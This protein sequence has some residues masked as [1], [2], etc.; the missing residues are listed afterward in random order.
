MP[1]TH[2]DFAQGLHTSVCV[3]SIISFDLLLF[4]E[5]QRPKQLPLTDTDKHTHTHAHS[6]TRTHK[7]DTL[8]A[9]THAWLSRRV[10]AVVCGRGSQTYALMKMYNEF[11]KCR[12]I[13]ILFM[14]MLWH[15][16]VA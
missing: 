6:Y 9:K 15:M 7:L 1:H 2:T 12:H 13:Y 4:V 11:A 10:L 14:Y 3:R 8:M 5:A 16:A